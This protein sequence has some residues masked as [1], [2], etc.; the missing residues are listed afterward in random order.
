MTPSGGE[1]ARDLVAGDRRAGFLTVLVTGA[2]DVVAAPLARHLG[3]E[4]VAANSLAL[5]A[6]GI[7]TG[8]LA[9]PVLAGP[10]KAV[11]VRRFAAAEAIDLERSRAY[12]DDT[13]DLPFLSS[14]GRPVAVNPDRKLRATAQAHGWP[15]LAL[16]RAPRAGILDRA[17]NGALSILRMLETARR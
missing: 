15:V 14:V 5:D 2:L 7:A 16:E 11:W 10:E 17:A 12:A 13:A 8:E 6:A 9:P 3:I 1:G 4:R